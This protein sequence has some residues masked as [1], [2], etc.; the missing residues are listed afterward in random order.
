MPGGCEM[1][2]KVLTTDP[3]PITACPDL[4][5]LC[6]NTCSPVC[7][8]PGLSSFSGSLYLWLSLPNSNSFLPFLFLFKS[9]VGIASLVDD[10]SP[11]GKASFSYILQGPALVLLCL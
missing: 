6:L 9:Q 8:S 3:P 5:G 4:L 2:F 10:P 11:H 1:K 7:P